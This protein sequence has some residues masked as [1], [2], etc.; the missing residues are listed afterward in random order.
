[1][2]KN[3]EKNLKNVSTVEKSPKTKNEGWGCCLDCMDVRKGMYVH[4]YIYIC[5]DIQMYLYKHYFVFYM[6]IDMYV[7]IC[8]KLKM[9]VDVAVWIVWM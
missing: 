2:T 7:Y 4:V 5:I 1:M 8:L 9:R 3:S 6:H